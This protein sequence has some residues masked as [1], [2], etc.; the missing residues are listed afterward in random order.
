MVSLETNE[1]R[2][3]PLL[4]TAL[5]EFDQITLNAGLKLFVLNGS[6]A[7]DAVDSTV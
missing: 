3:A 2:N 7:A 1:F 6:S 5:N 4:L